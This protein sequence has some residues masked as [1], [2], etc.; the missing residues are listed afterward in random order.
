MNCF[1]RRN[2]YQEFDQSTSKSI[3]TAERQFYIRDLKIR[4]MEVLKATIL[5]EQKRVYL[6]ELKKRK[7]SNVYIRTIINNAD[8]IEHL[9]AFWNIIIADD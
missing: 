2:D 5:Q 9:N 3:F 7:C 1:R 4:Q 8:T 6:L